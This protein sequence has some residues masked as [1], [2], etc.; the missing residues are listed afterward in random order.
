MTLKIQSRQGCSCNDSKYSLRGFAG[1]AFSNQLPIQTIS[2]CFHC[3]CTS[4]LHPRGVPQSQISTTSTIHSHRSVSKRRLAQHNTR[5][6]A[7]PTPGYHQNKLQAPVWLVLT[8][9]IVSVTC[10]A[11][12]SFTENSIKGGGEVGRMSRGSCWWLIAK[13][14]GWSKARFVQVTRITILLSAA[15]IR[16]VA[17]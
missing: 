9:R 6:Q 12:P 13:N 8:C 3:C 17:P 10:E 1:F 14:K 11:Y 16:V 5:T 2:F 15:A 4:W 7:L